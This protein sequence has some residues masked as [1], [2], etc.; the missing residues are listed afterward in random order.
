MSV[1]ILSSEGLHFQYNGIEILRDISFQIDAGDYVGIVGPNGSG[2][3][4]LIKLALGLFKPALGKILLFG[5]SPA[6]FTDWHKVGYLPQKANYFNPHFPATVREIV[7][8]GLLSRKGFPRR[9]GK[10]DNNMIDGALS[11]MDITNIKKKLIGE[12]S[13][14]QQQRV[15]IAKAM[16]SGPELLILDEPTTALDP[17]G[18][19]KFF[20]TLKELN[21]KKKLTIIMITHDMGTIGK[22]ASKLIYID[23]R[24][25]FFGGFDD[26]CASHDMATYFGEYSQ[27]VICHRHDNE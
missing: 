5:R 27:H 11:L 16:I 1:T 13:G 9:T 20:N 6:D 26:F 25:I 7:A 18:R 21:E 4:T 3:T 8:L 14:G 17:E 10:D 24:V 15:L 23:K 22:Y 19:E 12:L 2:K